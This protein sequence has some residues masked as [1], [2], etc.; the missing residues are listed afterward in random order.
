MSKE[1]RNPPFSEQSTDTYFFK[2]V[3]RA[4]SGPWLQKPLEATLAEIDKQSTHTSN[5]IT[6]NNQ[7]L[8]GGS[9]HSGM[10]NGFSTFSDDNENNN[11]QH[12]N[13]IGDET[14]QYIERHLTL[15]DL[16]SIG[17]GGTIGSGIFVLC[18]Y[19][20]STFAGP[21]TCVSWAIAGAAACLSGICY[22]ELA[23]RMPA[24]GS[25][26]VY[27]YASMGELPAVLVAAC[28]SLEYGISASAVARSWGDKCMEWLNMNLD[29]DVASF[30]ENAFNPLA[31]LVA[32]A[33]V[34]LLMGGVKESKSVTNF[35]TMA[36]VVLVVFMTVVGLALIKPKE[37]LVPFIPPQFGLVGIFRGATSSF[38]G[39]IGFDEVCCVAGEA[40]NP[41]RNMP[42]SIVISLSIVTTLYIIAALALTGM[43][44]YGDISDV[45]GFPLAFQSR[46]HE[47]AAQISAFGEVF[48]LPIVVLISLMAQP[49]LQY[50]L[51]KDGLLPQ[52]FARVDNDGNIWHGTVISGIVIVLIA[53]FVPFE[54]LNDMIS[55]GILVAFCMTD[56][57]LIIM[58]HESPNGDGKVENLLGWFNAA[59]LLFGISLT[60]FKENLLGNIVTIFSICGLL[61]CLKELY[62]CPQA[63]LFGGSIRASQYKGSVDMRIDSYFKTPFMP[64]I[65]CLGIFVNWYLISQLELIGIFFLVAYLGTA[66]LFYFSYGIHHSVGAN[67]GWD[68]YLS[69]NI[70]TTATFSEDKEVD[71]NAYLTSW[72]QPPPL[73]NQPNQRSNSDGC[74][75]KNPLFA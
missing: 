74:L 25:S 54:H 51:A 75:I 1:N 72:A 64:F 38:F 69:N 42:L 28:L 44:P 40:I 20:A 39:Y 65:P 13:I 66:A 43:Q 41:Q 6:A 29:I 18:G 14:E 17:V 27:V 24:A 57:S 2:P 61:F 63:I 68:Q 55:A 31:T 11:S 7:Q 26:Y 8:I 32:A 35:F 62:K 47:W 59:A 22:A 49:R 3:T 23:C 16:V 10:S 73:F 58:R 45:S 19:I 21:A 53:S 50:A 4:N 48:T 36:K 60:H 70:S 34:G 52:I 37:N 5:S 46:G 67:G 33:S 15:F 12:N 30:D 9:S 71:E 56:S